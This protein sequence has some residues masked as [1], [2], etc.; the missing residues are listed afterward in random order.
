MNQMGVCRKVLLTRRREREP[1]QPLDSISL[2]EAPY[3]PLT[4]LPN[5]TRSD[6]TPV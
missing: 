2:S 5:A 4:V 3:E 1:H 6:V